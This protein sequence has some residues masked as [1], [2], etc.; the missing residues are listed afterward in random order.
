M[1]NYWP[2]ITIALFL[3]LIFAVVFLLR[4][5]HKIPPDY[6]NFFIFGLCWIPVGII[7]DN[8]FFVVMGLV[9]VVLGLANRDKWQQNHTSWKDMPKDKKR[10]K[11]I[12]LVVLGAFVLAG[13]A[14]HFLSL[15]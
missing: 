9:F 3:L 15:K 12:L 14:V 6:L 4:K 7:T 11:I 1:F 5:K 8:M 10:L 13:F 2:F